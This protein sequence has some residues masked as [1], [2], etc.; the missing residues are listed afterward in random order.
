M[1]MIWNGKIVIKTIKGIQ[2]K[3]IFAY[4]WLTNFYIFTS[5]LILKKPHIFEIIQYLLIIAIRDPAESEE[6]GFWSTLLKTSWPGCIPTFIPTFHCV[7]SRVC[8]AF[9]LTFFACMSALISWPFIMY[10]TEQWISF[11]LK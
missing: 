1:N 9:P 5:S 2:G 8:F 4:F 6:L 3:D 7:V 11:P 10:K